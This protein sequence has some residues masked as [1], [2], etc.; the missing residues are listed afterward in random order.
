MRSRKPLIAALIVNAIIAGS[1][2]FVF[3]LPPSFTLVAD[4]LESY[5]TLQQ[6]EYFLG[7]AVGVSGMEP[8]ESIAIRQLAA[9]P[10]GG[11]A[12]K[13]LLVTGKPAGKMYALIGLRH[14]NPLFF[15]I[16]I[17]PFRIWP[18]EIHTI[19]G[20]IG[21]RVPIRDF[22]ASPREDRVQLKRGETLRGWWRRMKPGTDVTLDVLGGGYTSLF[23]DFEELARPAA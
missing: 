14:T 8:E 9:R 20:C 7:P 19:S 5:R 10:G 21:Q 13:Y 11:K 16:A 6:A 18:G 23:V 3:G 17:Q 15:S 2:F 22:V 1:W 12:F 4:D